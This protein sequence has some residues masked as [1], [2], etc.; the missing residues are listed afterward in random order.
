V[1]AGLVV[2]G[3]FPGWAGRAAE[4][5]LVVDSFSRVAASGWGTP[6]VGGA[7]SLE[8]WQ[9]HFSVAGGTGQVLFPAAGTNRAATVSGVS[10]RDVDV[11]VRLKTDKLA[12]GASMYAYIVARRNGN[13]SYRPKVIL[14]PGGG[15][16]VH[17]GVLVNNAESALGAPVIV[18]G[19]SHLQGGFIWLRSEISGANPTTVRVKAWSDGQPEPAGWQFSAANSAAGVQGAG[20]LGLRGYVSSVSNAPITFSFDDFAASAVEDPTATASPTGP[21]ATTPTPTPTP[22]PTPTAGPTAPPS[23]ARGL[24][25]DSFARNLPS[26]WGSAETGGS[27][28]FFGPQSDFFVNGGRGHQRL[29]TSGSTRIAYLPGAWGRDVDLKVSFSGDRPASGGGLYVYGALRGA[30][31]GSAYRPKLRIQT[32]GQIYA[33]VGRQSSSGE[34]SL[35]TA[36]L[37]PGVTFTPGGTIHLRATAT[38]V[39]PTTIRL[40]AWAAGQPEPAG[41]HFTATDSTP[42]LQQPGSIRLLSYLSSDA[43]NAPHVVSFDD[44]VATTTDA[45][46]VAGDIL[47]GAGDIASCSA[48]TDEAT[49][50]VL[51]GIAGTVFTLGDN[52]YPNATTSEFTNCYNPTWGRH[53]SRTKPIAGNHEYHTSQGNPYFAYFGAAAG[54][55]GRGWYAFDVGTWRVYALNSNCGQVS[56]T[57][58]S[59]QEQWLRAD[60]AANPRECVA[61]LMHHPRFSSGPHGDHPS[62][63]PFWRALYDAGADVVLA[64]HDHHY[65]RFAP[66]NSTGGTDPANGIREFVVGTGGIGLRPPSA[67]RP[68]SQVVH[69]GTH[70]VLKLTLGDGAYQWTFVPVA[71]RTFTDQGSSSCH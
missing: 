37:V 65:E 62:V 67:S 54:Q 69:G 68:N 43:T 46:P 14:T 6:D 10:I 28:S 2:A 49:A 12:A 31:D 40:R 71:G 11:R 60:L 29:S 4:A 22:L 35:G 64:G 41:W 34:T 3:Q 57:V 45:P 50:Q 70:G 18:A 47:V 15:V 32:N 53:R 23:G 36:A 16:A 19:L 48:T 52:V 61:A 66:M 1:L 21:P 59:E 17:A 56:C 9:S 27:Y 44:L 51:D 5:S 42:S 8:N 63:E 25:A 33:H 39:M 7:Y 13:N 20:G 30:A 38:G 58:G 26:G 24:A 55:P